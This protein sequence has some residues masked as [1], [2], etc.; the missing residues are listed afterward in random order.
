MTRW[1]TR[2]RDGE[3]RAEHK[4]SPRTRGGER[5]AETGKGIG[6]KTERIR[7][8][9]RDRNIN[10][11]TGIDQERKRI[12][13]KRQKD[14]ERRGRETRRR[15]VREKRERDRPTERQT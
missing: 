12:D 2:T 1:R 8:R 11:Q 4:T 9:K 3:R 14:R 6:N 7:A 15:T 10:R 5:L 13:V